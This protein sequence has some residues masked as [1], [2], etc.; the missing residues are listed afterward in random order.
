MSD[1][2]DFYLAFP[3]WQG[4]GTGN[5]LAEGTAATRRHFGEAYRFA[6]VDIA[7]DDGSDLPVERGIRGRSAILSQL[8]AAHKVI[9]AAKPARIFTVGGDCGVE[10]APIG[11]LNRLY[12]PQMAILWFDA[13]ADLHTPES[14]NSKNFHGMP[15]RHL[16]G[17]GDPNFLQLVS[18]S[19]ET[20]QVFLCGARS[21]GAAESAYLDRHPLL[22]R[23]GVDALRQRPDCL[24]EAL[25][26]AGFTY[27]YVH[28]DL[29]VLDPLEFP[30]VPCPEAGGL[31]INDLRCVGHALKRVCHLVGASILEHDG[32]WPNCAGD[33]RIGEVVSVVHGMFEASRP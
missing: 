27:V 26:S 17:E 13:H 12:G 3:Q 9:E 21:L 24:V 30:A 22:R 31:A 28:I 11:Y 1:D 19:L 10:L 23:F 2:A 25:A 7:S 20:S 15:L 14:S 18:P 32:R 29:D 5:G 8:R 33:Q 6:T 4:A 16:L